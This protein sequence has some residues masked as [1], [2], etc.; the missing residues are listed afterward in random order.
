M[1]E[2]E[3]P[4]AITLRCEEFKELAKNLVL[5]IA[6]TDPIGIDSKHMLNVVPVQFRNDVNP[7]SSEALLDQDWI[8]EPTITVGELLHRVE[9][10]L[11]TPIRI[12]RF[13]RYGVDDN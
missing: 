6:A 11:G 12:T 3:T 7:A 1:L 4:D 9:Q 2:L 8:K 10:Q 5:Q 13:T